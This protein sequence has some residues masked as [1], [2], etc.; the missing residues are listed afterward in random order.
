MIIPSSGELLLLL[1]SGYMKQPFKLRQFYITH[2]VKVNPYNQKKIHMKINL[3]VCKLKYYFQ[4]SP[5]NLRGI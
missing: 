1:Y 2:R 4:I 5:I 3:V